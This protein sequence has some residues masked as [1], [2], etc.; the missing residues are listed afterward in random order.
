MNYFLDFH[1]KETE[2]RNSLPICDVFVYISHLCITFSTGNVLFSNL[3][4][5][6][7]FRPWMINSQSEETFL[8]TNEK[9]VCSFRRKNGSCHRCRVLLMNWIF[10]R[11]VSFDYSSNNDSIKMSHCHCMYF[12]YFFVVY[13]LFSLFFSRRKLLSA[14][15]RFRIPSYYIALQKIIMR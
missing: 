6:I 7:N 9:F 8:P 4:L 12:H 5:S 13:S 14:T 2:Q 10:F 15:Q 11:L 1:L 3:P